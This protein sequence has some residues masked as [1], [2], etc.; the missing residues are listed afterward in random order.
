MENSFDCFLSATPT[1]TELTEH[2]DVSTNWYTV[3]T[4][5]DL[6]QKRLRSIEGQ[7]SHND[8]HKMIE[9]FNLW[10]ATTPTAS[11]RQVL[12]ALRKKVVGENTLADKYEKHLKEL[13]KA[14]YL[15]HISP[16][17][18]AVSILERNIESLNEALVSPV[19]VSQLLYC[20]RCIS[21]ATLDEMERMDQRRSLDDKKTIL[22]TAVQETVASDYKK[23]KNITIVLSD[24]EETRDIANDMMT[25]Y[26][27]IPQDNDST[28]VQLQGVV[29]D[30]EDRASDILRNNYST[31]SQSI[32]E[33]V[34]MAKLLHEEVISDEA[35]SCVMSTR[36]SVSDSRAVLLKAVRDAVHSNYKHL[37]LFV[38]VL[39]KF[40]E[41]AHI[42]DTI[43]EEYR[44]YFNYCDNDVKESDIYFSKQK[45]MSAS[46]E[47][48]LF[49]DN[50]TDKHGNHKILFPRD[51]KKKFK[52]MRSKFGS[53]FFRVR[54]IFYSKKTALNIDEMKELII[55][56][57]PDL[58]SQ[59]SYKMTINEILN[60]VKRKCSI[61][62]LSPL[63]N[64]AF[65]FNIEEAEPIIKSFKEEAK[66]FCKSVSV[67]LCLGEEL[68]AVATPSRLLCETVVFVFNWNPDK[69]TLQDIIDVLDELEPLHKCHIQIDKVGTG[70]S[71]VVT[72]YCPA[73]CTGLLKSIV[74]EKIDAL[75]IKELKEF[76]VGQDTVW[77]TTQDLLVQINDLKTALRDR[78]QKIMATE[79]ELA[80]FKEVSENR[81]KELEVLQIKLEESQCINAQNEDIINELKEKM[82]S[83]MK[84]VAEKENILNQIMKEREA[85]TEKELASLKE[86]SENRLQEVEQL[87]LKLDN[88]NIGEISETKDE[89]SE[90]DSDTSSNDDI[91]DNVNLQNE[92]QNDRE[93][94]WRQDN[95]QLI[96]PSADQCMEVI[97]KLED[98]H[99]SIML[100]RSSS[101]SIQVLLP[102][103]LERSTIE[104]LC[105]LSSFLTRE[106]IL[107]FSSQLSINKSLKI[108]SLAHDSISDDGVIALTQSLQCNE[109]LQY[110]Y[111]DYNPG[112][113]ASSA[114]LLAELLLLNNALS[115]LD[116]H[117]TNIDTDGVMMLMESLKTNN[118]LRIL[119]L[120]ELH[121]GT[122]STLPYYEHIK[123]RLDF[124]EQII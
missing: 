114:Q 5:L 57:F 81:L 79:T 14:A 29:G 93:V 27:K 86:L 96:R 11:R 119:G 34:H 49:D 45:S 95:V 76:I 51:M 109:T 77:D 124:V 107:S 26:G 17:S 55:D 16:S 31:L 78:D 87:K 106:D 89:S 90:S 7:T 120:D 1:I 59:L 41:T 3:G 2:V 56:L 121:Q 94:E 72:C 58:K 66:D 60:V 12:E 44:K 71:V 33:P 68:Q 35:L 115:Y 19:Q 110:L 113:T 63:E 100:I 20:K 62:D 13:H 103:I 32:T 36:G 99:I 15:D 48:S 9:M 8:A 64:L 43:F 122:C 21:E 80:I 112:I 54:R 65:E 101:E 50:E 117:R 23:L 74:L 82:S 38:N 118:T 4:M 39:R 25:N 111:L 70:R 22:L 84:E 97:S 10:L 52:E 6:D 88:N 24:V 61:V 85:N 123:N 37:E 83:L 75:R 47:S 98:R 67:S 73:E 18:E 28:L 92:V 104:I 105:I 40:S 69:C 116:L 108:L 53:T 91:Y 42:G 46:S 102:A 30:N